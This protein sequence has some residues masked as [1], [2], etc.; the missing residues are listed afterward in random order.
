[1]A[2]EAAFAKATILGCNNGAAGYAAD[3]E[4]KGGRRLARIGISPASRP[5]GR[6]CSNPTRQR[7]T[8]LPR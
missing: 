5:T 2:G 7:E 6:P 3:D 4:S 1:M 8:D